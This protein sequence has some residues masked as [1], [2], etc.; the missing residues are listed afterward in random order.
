MY[1]HVHL[2]AARA[3][4]FMYSLRAT[5]TQYT[6]TPMQ[7]PHTQAHKYNNDSKYSPPSSL[8]TLL[9]RQRT[10]IHIQNLLLSGW[11]V[12]GNIFSV[13]AS[14]KKKMIFP[15]FFFSKPKM[16]LA[17]RIPSPYIH[18]IYTKFFK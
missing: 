8:H 16:L 4:K 6:Y 15:Q 7:C 5:A 18:L 2:I 9:H 3:N 17:K 13:L 10:C 14:I 11:R 1:I 12:V